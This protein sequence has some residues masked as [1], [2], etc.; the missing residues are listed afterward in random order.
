MSAA[1]LAVLGVTSLVV[2]TALGFVLPEARAVTWTILAC[3][4][5][6]LAAALVLD[7][8]RDRSI[9]SGRGLFGIGATLRV[10]LFLGIVLLANAISVSTYHRFDFTGLANFTLS[11]QTK[12]FLGKLDQ[13]VEVVSFFSPGPATP[14]ANFAAS[15]LA[16]YHNYTSDLVLR[17]VDPQIS[18]DQARQYGIDST[19]ALLGAV[20]FSGKDGQR[21]VIGPQIIGGAEYAFTSAIMEVTGA[22]QPRIYFVTGHGEPDLNA[23]YDSVRQALRDDLFDVATLDLADASS[24]PGDAALVVI[25]GP[26]R[27]PSAAELEKLQTY[28]KN[29]G[30]LLVL[31]DP[32][33]PPGLRQFLK[34]WWIDVEDGTIVEPDKHVYPNEDVALVTK[35]RDNFGLDETYFPGATAVIPQEDVPANVDTGA[36]VWTTPQAWLDR[37]FAPG[38]PPVLDAGSE[39][40]GPLAIGA[41]LSVRPGA[42]ASGPQSRLIVIGDSDF[43]ANAHFNNGQNGSLFLDAVGWL[44]SDAKIVSIDRKVIASRR[45]LLGPE[46]ARFVQLSSIAL[47]PLLLVVGGGLAWWRRR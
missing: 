27:D 22:R 8:R 25:A 34:T 6:L 39:R 47:L 1:L 38:K 21:R 17:S 4:T 30:R 41:F 29:G 23:D 13:P 43:A 35:D 42:E 10:S 28:L 19:A 18:P 26:R 24:V 2:A 7:L 40:K 33:P 31:L 46:Q 16:E 32:N 45:L 15:L 12:D 11:A 9:V 44:T 20:V 14:V 36:L 5:G 3:G 37:D